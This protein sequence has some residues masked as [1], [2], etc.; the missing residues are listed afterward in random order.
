MKSIVLLLTSLMMIYSLQTDILVIRIAEDNLKGFLADFFFIK[1]RIQMQKE[2]NLLP[3]S[4]E[5]NIHFFYLK[6]HEI[7]VYQ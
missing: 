6:I 3:S 4:I 2:H 7:S 1:W 5:I